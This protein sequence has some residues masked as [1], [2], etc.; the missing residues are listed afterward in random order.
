MRERFHFENAF[1]Q[2]ISFGP[3]YVYGQDF[4]MDRLRSGGGV[5]PVEVDSTRGH[6]GR[7]SMRCL[8][9]NA[10]ISTFL[11]PYTMKSRFF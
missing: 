5:N 8:R 6:A 1:P 2:D 3:G 11:E 7:G 9:Y 4:F 10:F